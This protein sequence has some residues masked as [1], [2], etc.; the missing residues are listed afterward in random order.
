MIF[1][2][3]GA[4]IACSAPFLHKLAPKTS[5]K[6][7]ALEKSFKKG[8]IDEAYFNSELE[9]LKEEFKTFGYS[10]PRKFWYVIGKPLTMLYFAF[11]LL[12]VYKDLNS[13]HLRKAL[14]VSSLVLLYISTYNIIW[15]IWPGYD[16]PDSTYY[17]SMAL[18]SLMATVLSLSWLKYRQSLKH[19]IGL[20]I[21][22][23]LTDVYK[24]YIRKEHT[25][26]YIEDSYSV[27][28]KIRK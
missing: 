13:A 2:I 4:V 14:Y 18:M 19:K 16:L 6:I 7:K 20:L 11:L 26:D 9:I 8:T 23:I 1:I 15:A 22:F 12:F 21:D 24:K 5:S 3:L 28:D 17:F 27:F 10:T 25:P